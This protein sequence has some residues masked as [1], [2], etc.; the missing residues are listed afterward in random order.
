LQAAIP[1]ES[2]GVQKDKPAANAI[3]AKIQCSSEILAAM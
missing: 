2:F 1:Q 3:Q